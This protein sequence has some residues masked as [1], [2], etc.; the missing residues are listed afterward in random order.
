MVFWK[1][2]ES[3]LDRKYYSV[4]IAE[5]L[6][7]TFATLL[8]GS[9]NRGREE[10]DL[11][12]KKRVAELEGEHKQAIMEAHITGFYSEPFGKSRSRT[13]EQY[14]TDKYKK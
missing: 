3:I 1:R 7:G 11:I 2:N 9:K 10:A 13:A 8:D 12:Y 6:S 5:E 14:Y 4:S